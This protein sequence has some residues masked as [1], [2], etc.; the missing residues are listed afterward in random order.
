M[1]GISKRTN[2]IIPGNGRVTDEGWE[3]AGHRTEC[4]TTRHLPI[5]HGTGRSGTLL[6]AWLAFEYEWTIYTTSWW[7]CYYSVSSSPSS[8]CL[9]INNTTRRFPINF[10]QFGN[11]SIFCITLACITY[12]LMRWQSADG[13]DD[14]TIQWATVL[15]HHRRWH[16]PLHSV[17]PTE[18]LLSTRCIQLCTIRMGFPILFSV[19]WSYSAPC[20]V[21]VFT[22]IGMQTGQLPMQ[23]R[24]LLHAGLLH[25]RHRH[26]LAQREGVHFKHLCRRFPSIGAF[27][28]VHV[29]RGRRCST[30]RTDEVSGHHPFQVLLFLYFRWLNLC[31]PTHA[32]QN[33]FLPGYAPCLPY[34]WY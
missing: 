4:G 12:V 17:Y 30:V 28:H 6:T 32:L 31:H 21:N 19:K 14:L 7:V 15:R 9:I 5:L 22:G 24:N 23:P 26:H 25:R 3:K 27:R 18:S 34:A 2:K 16:I 1:Q 13:Y 11:A 8:L 20:F 10:K 29:F 33:I